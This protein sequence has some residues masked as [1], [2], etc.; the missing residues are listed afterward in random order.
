M[1]A[2]ITRTALGVLATAAVAGALVSCSSDSAAEATG[3]SQQE[4]SQQESSQQESSQAGTSQSASAEAPAASDNLG[5]PATPAEQEAMT[6]VFKRFVETSNNG[7]SAGYLATLCATDPDREKV[8]SDQAPAPNPAEVDDM[9]DFSVDGDKGLATVTVSVSGTD[10]TTRQ[11][12][13]TQ[14]NFLRESGTW[15]VCGEH[16]N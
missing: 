3:S 12:F 5:A 13:V 10:S 1:D 11:Q 4:S 9:K 14:F 8:T 6:E 15:T 16:E 2:S 7:D